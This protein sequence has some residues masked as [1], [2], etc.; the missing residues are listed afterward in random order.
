M[1]DNS[2]QTSYNVEEE[3]KQP[4]NL[5][6]IVGR[7]LDGFVRLWWVALIFAII[8][9]AYGYRKYKNSYVPN[10]SAQATFYLKEAGSGSGSS[11]ATSSDL[12]SEIST[13]FDYLINNE[14]FYEILEKELGLDY[15]PATITVSAVPS[16]N[17]LS[18]VAT[19]QDPEM[20]LK[21]IKAVLN[22]YTDLADIVMGDTEMT[23]L[24]DPIMSITPNNSYSPFKSTAKWALI[25]AFI[26]LIPT[27]LYAF[28]IKTIKSKDDIE[29]LLSVTC[30]GALPAVMLN[31]KE[32][33]LKNCSILNKSVGF[34]YL[35]SMRS[36][37]SR[38]EKEMD[39]NGGKVFLV[40]STM[41][42]E[43]KSTIA[44]NL[45]YSLSK[46]QKKV[47]LLDGN[48]RKPS[49]RIITEAEIKKDYSMEDFLDKKVKSSEA[50][51]NIPDTRVLLLAPNKPAE[52]P[53]R[54]LN[55]EEMEQFINESKEVV[56]Y[57]IID[58][59]ECTDLAD[60]AMLAKHSDGVIYVIKEDY[61]RVNRIM[62]TIQEF[63]YTKVPIIG[64]VLNGTIKALKLA[65]GYSYLRGYGR[66]YSRGYYR[67][68]YYS[69]GYYRYR[70]Y[71]YGYGGYGRGY[72]Y[73]YGNYGGGYGEYGDY[74]TYGEVSDKEFEAKERKVSK[75]VAMTTTEEQEKA[76]IASAQ[77]ELK[78]EQEKEAEE[79][80]N[81]KGKRNKKKNKSDE[82]AE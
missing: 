65:Y 64:C 41:E 18:I 77:E 32:K 67:A 9:G 25:G 69:R 45:A 42:G 6:E 33:N 81:K 43:G 63:S 20:N 36:M 73:G 7:F 31:D 12:A 48:L 70:G 53:A 22:N 2:Y 3:E 56:D 78:K 82:A 26:G 15:M 35:E 37:T 52:N 40:T 79:L 27:L 29:K 80:Q 55:S 23:I 62:D 17:I 68:G 50:I 24:D 54:C 58:S 51:I 72:G 76:L 44:M 1:A 61:A 59:P 39:K 57:I 11:Y 16:T 34:R 21:V 30:F 60:V 5:G 49:L 14:V 71:G 74:G 10:Y 13:S 28:F 47:M 8:F 66:G 4:L 19:G 75:N 38:C 46:N